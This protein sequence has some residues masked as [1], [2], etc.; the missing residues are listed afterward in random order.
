V[1]VHCI[2]SHSV[3]W[4]SI[5]VDGDSAAEVVVVAAAAA[6]AAMVAVN[7]RPVALQ[8]PKGCEDSHTFR[9]TI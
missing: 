8:T 2:H 3:V 4:K 5:I 1:Q 9:Q 7:S 6:A